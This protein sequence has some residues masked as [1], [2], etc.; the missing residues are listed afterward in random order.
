MSATV[1]CKRVMRLMLR[2]Q[3]FVALKVAMP[4]FFWLSHIDPDQEDR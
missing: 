3:C 4:V 2:L 1:K